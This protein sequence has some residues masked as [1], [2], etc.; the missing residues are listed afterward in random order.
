MS[1]APVELLLQTDGPH[2][3]LVVGTRSQLTDAVWS[4]QTDRLRAGSV[5][6]VRGAKMRS[7]GGLFDECAAALQFPHYFG[8]NWDALSDCL[9]DLTWLPGFAH[10]LVVSDAVLLL[11]DEPPPAL[12]TLL[13]TLDTAAMRWR[14]GIAEGQLWD[15]APTPFSVAFH[16]EAKDEALLVARFSA[17][18]PVPMRLEAAS[19]I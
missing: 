15:R 5:R 2:L 4:L 11:A 1:A 16:C 6:L 17:V 19:L 14:A 9:T 3:F 8:E 10:L 7:E 18:G 12:A 13:R